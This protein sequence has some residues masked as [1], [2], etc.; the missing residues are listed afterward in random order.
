VNEIKK[1]KDN[2]ESNKEDQKDRLFF[3]DL[4][5]QTHGIL[6]FLGLKH[7]LDTKDIELLTTEVKILQSLL[8][9]HYQFIHKNLATTEDDENGNPASQFKKVTISLEKLINIYY[10]VDATKMNISHQGEQI[11]MLDFISLYRILNNIVKNMS[12]AKVVA[13]KLLL[14]FNERGLTITT[15]NVVADKK[16]TDKQGGL[17]LSSIA[18]L[19]ALA[20]GHFQYEIHSDTWINQIFLPYLNSSRD[21]H[22]IKKIAA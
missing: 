19:A 10:P 7:S 11:A 20:G 4:I 5:N 17:G 8:Q 6:L 15:Q 3:H 13:A 14:D 9:N 2:K 1:P 12:E 16:D 22:N 18:S 21:A